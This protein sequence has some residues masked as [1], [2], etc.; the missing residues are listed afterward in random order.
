M[1]MKK[2]GTLN[3]LRGMKWKVKLKKVSQKKLEPSLVLILNDFKT[4]EL[5]NNDDE[6]NIEFWEGHLRLLSLY[7]KDEYKL[8]VWLTKILSGINF[9]QMNN[10]ARQSRSPHGLRRRINSWLM[11]EYGKLEKGQY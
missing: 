5:V 1:V 2:I 7:F 10:S 9:W 6:K 4:L 11:K 8:K 3:D